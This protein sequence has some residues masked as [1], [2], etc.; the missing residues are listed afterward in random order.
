MITMPR[1][2]LAERAVREELG[3]LP[4]RKAGPRLTARY[5]ELHQELLRRLRITTVHAN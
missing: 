4:A 2:A 3:R 5:Q 1:R